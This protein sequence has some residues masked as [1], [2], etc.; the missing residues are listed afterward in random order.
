MKVSEITLDTVRG[1]ARMD[2]RGEDVSPKL[3]L[4]AAKAFVRGYTG[5]TD[6]QIDQHED[7]TAAVLMLCTD[8]YDNRQLTV[9]APRANWLAEAIL[10]LYKAAQQ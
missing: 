8:L 6:E 9:D 1:Y 3:L 5:M 10:S 7:L 2:G 4:E